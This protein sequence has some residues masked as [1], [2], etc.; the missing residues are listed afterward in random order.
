MT[1]KAEVARGLQSRVAPSSS[2]VEPSEAL[3][4]LAHTASNAAF[5]IHLAIVGAVATVMEARLAC[6]RE[7]LAFF[8]QVPRLELLRRLP[9]PRRSSMRLPWGGSLLQF[10]RPSIS[11]SGTPSFRE[12]GS[13]PFMTPRLRGGSVL[14]VLLPRGVALP[15]RPSPFGLRPLG[16][17]L[18]RF[19]SIRLLLSALQ[20]SFSSTKGHGSQSFFSQ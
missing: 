17:G 15:F 20:S 12:S 7:V 6:H 10:S 18:G 1:F 9:L 3:G 14:R 2:G 11:W 19:H 5:Q 8:D 16:F 13:L 4:G